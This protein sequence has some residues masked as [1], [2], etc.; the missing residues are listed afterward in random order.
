MERITLEGRRRKARERTRARGG[1][2]GKGKQSGK[3]PIVCTGHWRGLQGTPAS[4]KVMRDTERRVCIY[5]CVRRSC[6]PTDRAITAVTL[7]QV[8]SRLAKRHH[9]SRIVKKRNKRRRTNDAVEPTLQ[10]HTHTHS[11]TGAE[12]GRD[13]EEQRPSVKVR[14]RER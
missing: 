4:I 8:H 2:N 7:E 1:G 13:S 5:V 6:A 10:T 9:S 11:H 3:I 14:E 12:R